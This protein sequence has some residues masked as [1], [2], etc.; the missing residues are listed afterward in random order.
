MFFDLS[1]KLETLINKKKEM[2]L[3]KL[4]RPFLRSNWCHLL[5]NRWEDGAVDRL[6]GLWGDLSKCSRWRLRMTRIQK[7]W[8]S[9][10]WLVD[11]EGLQYVRGI[12]WWP[13]V[14]R[15]R[16]KEGF[17]VD[18]MFLFRFLWS[19]RSLFRFYVLIC[20]WNKVPVLWSYLKSP[21]DT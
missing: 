16:W 6:D 4:P 7:K 19:M 2:E 5:W 18:Q 11:L 20:P 14:R 15:W 10:A 8:G 12:G 3:V 21:K 9:G 1:R 13:G 17:Y